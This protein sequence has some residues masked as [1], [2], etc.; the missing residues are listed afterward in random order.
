MTGTI[1][2]TINYG[3]DLNQHRWRVERGAFCVQPGKKWAT[4]A[5]RRHG[6]N[7]VCVA[8]W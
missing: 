6:Q 1:V 3:Y 8:N 5:E 2:T 4:V 7:I